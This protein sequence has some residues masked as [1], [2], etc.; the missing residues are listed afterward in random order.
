MLVEHD[1]MWSAM[2]GKVLLGIDVHYACKYGAIRGP[3]VWAHET[4]CISLW[5]LDDGRRAALDLVPRL[6]QRL[7]V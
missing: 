7:D 4:R 2:G 1:E 5:V 6:Q 3:I